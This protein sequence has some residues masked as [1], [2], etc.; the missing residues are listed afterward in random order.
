VNASGV[1]AHAFSDGP[2]LKVRIRR[3]GVWG[4]PRTVSVVNQAAKLGIPSTGNTSG[5]GFDV[6]VA[7]DGH[8]EVVFPGGENPFFGCAWRESVADLPPL[9]TGL[10]DPADRDGDGTADSADNCPD[11][12]NPISACSPQY[13]APPGCYPTCG[14]ESPG[15][16]P[17]GGSLPPLGRPTGI[18][19]RGLRIGKLLKAGRHR[20]TV[21]LPR[22]GTLELKWLKGRT[23]VAS[24]RTT[25]SSL[26]M[27]LT[28]K[29][30]KLLRRAKKAE[31]VAKG[32]YRSGDETRN[33]AKAFTLKR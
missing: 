12:A 30:R 17:T 16:G 9:C 19:P 4:T 31:L 14:T 26:T 3:D 29:G 20:L 13:T 18:T 7:P 22:P 24:G 6:A 10:A 21:G 11:E 2:A 25:S 8:V 27:K 32:V 15:T 1:A 23:V 5:P 33:L 28:R